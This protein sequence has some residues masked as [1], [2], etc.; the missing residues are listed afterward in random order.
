M[1]N[2]FFFGKSNIIKARFIILPWRKKNLSVI[3]TINNIPTTKRKLSVISNKYKAFFIAKYHTF[4]FSTFSM[5]MNIYRPFKP[6]CLNGVYS[7]IKTI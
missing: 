5:M 6:K 3:E 4:L 2:N 1:E 7:W